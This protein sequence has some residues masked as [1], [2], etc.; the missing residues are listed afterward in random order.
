MGF[1]QKNRGWHVDGKAAAWSGHRGEYRIGAKK[2]W[3]GR[4]FGDWNHNRAREQRAELSGGG[5]RKPPRL[6]VHQKKG[7]GKVL[8]GT[9]P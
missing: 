3:K 1:Q 9:C 5:D 4:K 2:R 6:P 7:L 8:R